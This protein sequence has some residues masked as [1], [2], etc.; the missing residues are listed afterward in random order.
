MN[1]KTCFTCIY[2]KVTKKDR[3][4]KCTYF[5][6]LGKKPKPIPIEIVDKG[7]KLYKDKSLQDNELFNYIMKIFNGELI[8]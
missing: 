7:C 2:Q 1:N 8:K 4:G 6:K 3:I 5:E